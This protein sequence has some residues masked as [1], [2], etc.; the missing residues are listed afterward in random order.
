MSRYY[1]LSDTRIYRDCFYLLAQFILGTLYFT[2]LVTGY[3]LGL[4]L[5]ILI[6]GLP[7]LRLTNRL[8][9]ILATLDRHMNAAWFSPVGLAELED[10]DLQAAWQSSRQ[11]GLA[12]AGYLLGRSC[13]ASSP[14]TL[15]GCCCRFSSSKCW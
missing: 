3:S 13:W 2:V 1:P 12:G 10:F 11:G 15:S 6:I 8:A 7:I 4:S 9:A 5:L 14:S